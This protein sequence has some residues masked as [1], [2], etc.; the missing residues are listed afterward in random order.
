MYAWV[1]LLHEEQPR[2]S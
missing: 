2:P 1:E